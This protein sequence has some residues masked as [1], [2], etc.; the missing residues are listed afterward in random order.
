MTEQRTDSILADW[1]E[2]R[3]RGDTIPPQT[4]IAAH[5]ECASELRARFAALEFV[6]MAL[7][8]GARASEP[9]RIDD[10]RIALEDYST[11][12][13]PSIDWQSTATGNIRVLNDTGDFYRFFDATPQTEFLYG[14]VQ[15][16]I[17][18]DLPEETEFLR[19]YDTFRKQLNLVVDM[20]DR[21][22]DL[23]F[24]F[25]H[26]NKGTLS[27]RSREKEFTAL[28]DDEVDR[29]EAIYREV[30]VDRDH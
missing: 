20:P 8:R 14:C 11:R 5:P 19:R 4:V 26:Q 24:R 23:L 10:Y 13:L 28:T 21:V 12:L 7:A 15:R 27:G 18:H 30:F 6:D 22:L 9:S 29:I 16:T 3:D 25:L 1:L 2:R 17:E